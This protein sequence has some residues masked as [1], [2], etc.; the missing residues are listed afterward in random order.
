VKTR[1][2]EL[3]ASADDD[4]VIPNSIDMDAI[5]DTQVVEGAEIDYSRRLD[6]DANPESLLLALAE[7]RVKGWHAVVVGDGPERHW[8]KRQAADLPQMT[9]NEEFARYDHRPC[10]SGTS[11]AI[12]TCRIRSVS[13]EGR[14]RIFRVAQCLTV[15]FSLALYSHDPYKLYGCY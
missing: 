14:Y 11:T 13:S 10:W 12:V 4:R 1:V 7:L 5:R 2:R 6:E 15:A 3:G 9:E 8:Y